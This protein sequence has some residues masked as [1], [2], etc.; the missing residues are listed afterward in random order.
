MKRTLSNASRWNLFRATPHGR[1]SGCSLDAL[2]TPALQSLIAR[3]GRTAEDL[4]HRAQQRA[5][6]LHIPAGA[7]RSDPV[8]QQLFFVLEGVL[9]ELAQAQATLNRRPGQAAGSD[10][11][12]QQRHRRDKLRIHVDSAAPLHSDGPFRARSRARGGSWQARP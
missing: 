4:R 12:V 11:G 10:P 2:H 1:S 3:L 9:R 7:P 5:A 6:M 8:Y